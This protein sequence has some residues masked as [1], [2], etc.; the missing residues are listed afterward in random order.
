MGF[1]CLAA[2]SLI[3][4]TLLIISFTG[5]NANDI[6]AFTLAV[7]ASMATTLIIKW[8]CQTRLFCPVKD[9]TYVF[10]AVLILTVLLFATIIVYTLHNFSRF[11]SLVMLSVKDVFLPFVS[12]FAIALFLGLCDK[13]VIFKLSA[14]LLPTILIILVVLFAYS[15]RFMNVK[16][17]IP[18]KA[19]DSSWFQAFLPLYLSLTA[20][21]LPLVIIGKKE[22]K[23]VFAY[24]F[25]IA[26]AIIGV[27]VIT[28]LG[29]FGSEFASTL[30]YPYLSAVGTAAMGEIFSRFD[31]FFYF[32]C[33]FSVLIK[34]ALCIYSFKEIFLKFLNFTIEKRK[35]LW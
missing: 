3:G 12:V 33:F 5:N 15:V 6:I 8:F 17:F 34:T 27:S 14:I 22:K 9:K 18:Y 28:V 7:V 26:F 16:Y 30:D 2:L 20:S 1:I 11:A 29:I 10:G 23:S 31:G 19:L 32:V 13:K 4:N 21:S 35:A 24:A 25:L